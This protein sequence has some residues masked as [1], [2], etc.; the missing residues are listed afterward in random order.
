[1]QWIDSLW[2]RAQPKDHEAIDWL[3]QYHHD[4]LAALEHALAAMQ[5]VQLNNQDHS[6]AVGPEVIRQ[7]EAAIALGLSGD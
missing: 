4:S 2:P 1:M 6:G 3:K 7:V 5:C